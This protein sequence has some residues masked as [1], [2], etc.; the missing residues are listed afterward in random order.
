MFFSK[1]FLI[2]FSIYFLSFSEDFSYHGGNPE[3]HYYYEVTDLLVPRGLKWAV[4]FQ[5]RGEEE[6]YNPLVVEGRVYFTSSDGKLHVLDA[7]TGHPIWTADDYW[8]DLIIKD[9]IL[10]CC[11]RTKL[12]A[13]DL[14]SREEKEYETGITLM[15]GSKYWFGAAKN[16]PVLV[17]ERVYFTSSSSWMVPGNYPGR[18]WALDRRT[19]REIWTAELPE[20]IS[21]LRMS[22][23]PSHNYAYVCTWGT[24]RA[25][26]PYPNRYWYGENNAMVYAID[27][28]TGQIAHSYRL[29]RVPA[30]TIMVVE[31]KVVVITASRIVVLNA[32]NLQ[33]IRLRPVR[34]DDKVW[35]VVLVEDNK[36]AFP[37]SGVYGIQIF[38]L[39][40]YRKDFIPLPRGKEFGSPLVT[41][42]MLY[43]HD[44]DHGREARIF[45][46]DKESME[47]KW[48]W[49]VSDEFRRY[50]FIEGGF[51]L[52]E[53]R[54]YYGYRAGETGRGV[55]CCLEGERERVDRSKSEKRVSS[56]SYPNPFN[57]EC[58]IPVNAKGKRQ[59]VKCKIYNIL[60][61]LVREI[62]CSNRSSRSNGSKVYWDGKD[63][64]GLEVPSGVYF[65]EV[66]GE[67]VR[68]MIVL[69]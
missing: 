34:G 12:K 67:R 35:Q 27:L 28:N 24:L 56:L 31:E 60:G 55:I 50:Q 53:G 3:G 26:A 15:T 57:P 7:D 64:R 19:L 2:F 5:R 10:Y 63:T 52:C 44:V 8:G 58:Y 62:D 22:I 51:A 1:I 6:N 14:E 17:G 23:S 4:P 43:F 65:Y 30:R 54:I 37:Q 20:A 21:V 25:D 32:T 40:N 59:N 16:K 18:I 42:K 9:G 46:Y 33:R 47:E 68:K 69:R 61:Q 41:S 38:D 49:L 29:G 39:N 36:I 45:A 48:N 66:A 11:G 13:L